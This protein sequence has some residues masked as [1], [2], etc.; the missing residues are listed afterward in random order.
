MKISSASRDAHNTTG[1]YEMA[2]TVVGKTVKHDIVVV[3]NINSNT[4]LG[5]D[6]TEHSAIV[7]YSKKRDLHLKMKN[8]NFV[9]HRCKH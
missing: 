9:K 2:I 3:Q 8:R 6:L 5:I 7:Y 1:I 4:I